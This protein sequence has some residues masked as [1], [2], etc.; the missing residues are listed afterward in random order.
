M[1]D[2]LAFAAKAPR[3]LNSTQFTPFV[4]APAGCILPGGQKNDPENPKTGHNN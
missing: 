4:K 3:A 2:A 1:P